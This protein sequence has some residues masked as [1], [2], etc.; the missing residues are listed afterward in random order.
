M[1]VHGSHRRHGVQKSLVA[2]GSERMRPSVRTW[3]PQPRLSADPNE[4]IVYRQAIGLS[5]D[6]VISE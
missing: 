5:P 4:I 1:Q 3:L 6:T 2:G